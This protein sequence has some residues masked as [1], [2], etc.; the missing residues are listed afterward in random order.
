VTRFGGRVAV[1]TGA[2]SGIGKAI[3]RRLAA[4]GALVAVVDV[5][6]RNAEA[7]AE[8]IVALGGVA[9]AVATDVTSSEEVDRSVER[10]TSHFGRLDILVNNAG[11][12]GLSSEL[13][14]HA[15]AATMDSMRHGT[16]TSLGITQRMG[17]AEWSRMLRVHVDGTFAFT[18]AALRVM[19][20]ARSGVIVNM[21]SIVAQV[22]TPDVPHY[23]A[24]KGAIE[25]FTRAVAA[26]VGGAGIRVNC[27]APGFIAT[28]MTTEMPPAIKA[29]F[30]RRVALAREGLPEDVAGVVAFLASDDAAYVSGHVLAVDG[31]MAMWTTASFG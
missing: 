19:E 30:L 29:L 3:G 16:T 31:G 12:A 23:S 28:P 22:G 17:D 5:D 7:A 26:E 21:S 18:R 13:R 11:I 14:N 15:R 27:V 20:P 9:I 1:I 2:A 10:V 6:A 25:G 4:E 24:A 8:E